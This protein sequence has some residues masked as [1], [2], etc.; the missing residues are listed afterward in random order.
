MPFEN[1]YTASD[2]KTL[3]HDFANDIN[4]LKMNLQTLEMMR[5]D[6]ELHAK[7]IQLM[8]DSVDILQQRIRSTLILISNQN[9]MG[10][11]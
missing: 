2:L 4:C 5:D 9:E 6:A 7:L 1:S 11:S 10:S 8:N 3:T